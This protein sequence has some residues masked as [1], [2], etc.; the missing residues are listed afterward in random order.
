[1]V[2][3]VESITHDLRRIGV[4]PGATVMVHASLRRI[5]ATEH[6]A[7]AVI[8]A[9]D[10]AVGPDGTWLMVLGA[11]GPWAWVNAHPPE[12]RAE[13]LAD[14]PAFDKDSTP[15]DPDVGALAEVFRRAPGT[16]VNDHPDARFGA[17]GHRAHALLTDLPWD[18]YYGVDSVLDRFVSSDGQVLR[19]GADPD[20]VTLLHHAEYL[21]ELPGKRRV[22]RHHRVMGTDGQPV[23]R[24]VSCLDDTDGIVEWPSGDYFTDVLDDY[25]S[26]GAGSRRLV[27]GASSELLEAADLLHFAV[28]WMNHNLV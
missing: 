4:R 21:C 20:T 12:D 9:M 24:S 22:T 3:S 6:D 19:L 15:A 18:D 11:R 28:E 25:L 16:V 5:G 1:M 10:D 17:R 23:V 13:L 2:L 7:D 8:T 14:A 26:A 27:G